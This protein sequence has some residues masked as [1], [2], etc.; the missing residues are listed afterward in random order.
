MIGKGQ[1]RFLGGGLL[2]VNLE[3]LILLLSKVQ[4]KATPIYVL[5][6]KIMIMKTIPSKP[7]ERVAGSALLKSLC[8]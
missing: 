7:M 3:T 1:G 5:S 2:A 8:K 6:N 4:Y